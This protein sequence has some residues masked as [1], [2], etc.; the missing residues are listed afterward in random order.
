MFSYHHHTSGLILVVN[1]CIVIYQQVQ[2]DLPKNQTDH[3]QLRLLNTSESIKDC[4]PQVSDVHVTSSKRNLYPSANGASKSPLERLASTIGNVVGGLDGQDSMATD[5]NN[6]NNGPAGGLEGLLGNAG[7]N[8]D[9]ILASNSGPIGTINGVSFGQ[10]PVRALLVAL[11]ALLLVQ[12]AN[13]FED[14]APTTSPQLLETATD[15]LEED[16]EDDGIVAAQSRISRLT[17]LVRGAA[18]TVGP[19]SALRA[20]RSYRLQ[21]SPLM[22]IEESLSDALLGGRS[23][24]DGAPLGGSVSAVLMAVVHL[25]QREALAPPTLLQTSASL[26]QPGTSPIDALEA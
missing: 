14:P 24:L 6:N 15:L 12:F 19:L 9:A 8:M 16:V 22:D 5:N 20:L 10:V 13:E 11:E 3:P 21:A 1:D 18:S 25:L 7:M 17:T 23:I 26:L 2:I 4:F